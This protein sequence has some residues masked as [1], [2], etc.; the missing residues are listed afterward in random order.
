MIAAALEAA[1]YD[2]LIVPVAM[3]GAP[4]EAIM[5]RAIAEQRVLVTEDKDFGELAF[6]H[7]HRPP[8]LIRLVL[9]GFWPRQKADRLCEVVRTSGNKILG[10]AVVVEPDRVR[11]RQFPNV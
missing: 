7:G 1:G 10:H 11:S 3:P 8:S 5:D 2:V 4:D 9:P 6:K